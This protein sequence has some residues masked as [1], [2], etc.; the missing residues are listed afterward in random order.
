MT[1]LYRML[2][3]NLGGFGSAMTVLALCVAPAAVVWQAAY[4]ESLALFL[5]L[6]ALWSLRSRR[7]GTLLMV[8]LA[9]ALTR[10]VV[11]PLALVAGLHWLARW[12]HRAVEPFPPREAVRSG[13]V[14]MAMAASFL[15]WPVVA[16]MVTHRRD[17]YFA[18][19]SAWFAR[20]TGW[21]TWLKVFVGGSDLALTLVVAAACAALVVVLV[22]APAR[23]WGFELRTWAWA[24]PLYI[25]GSTRPTTSIT[26]YAL[27]AIVPWWPFPEIGQ[28]VTA[29]RDRLA[30][31]ALVTLLGIAAQLVWL[32]WFWV[33]G[34]SNIAIP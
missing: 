2:A 3:P 6:A 14:I 28:Q 8:A 5:I 31:V 12:R 13:C 30:L 21:P 16:A 25:L 9:L 32:R 34:P 4:T 19:Q 29:R 10:P 15:L 33:I 26:R 27:L 7:Y 20:N 23:L 17:A 11:L 18:T 1:L 22:R 24:Y